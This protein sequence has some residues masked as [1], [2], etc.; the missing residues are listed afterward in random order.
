MTIAVKDFWLAVLAAFIWGATFPITA[1][2]ID[3]T[4]PIF[5]AFLRFATAAVFVIFFPRPKVPILTL[6]ALGLLLGVGQFGVMFV[7]MTK[8]VSAGLASLLVHTQAFF[9]VIIAMIVFSERITVRQTFAMLIA[10]AGLGLFAFDYFVDGALVG[11][12]LIMVAALSAATVNTIFKTLGK[13]DM[14]GVSV[15]MSLASPIPL[16]LFSTWFE[17]GGDMVSLFATINWVVI[18]AAAYSAIFATLLVYTIWGRLLN[19]Y[20]TV[21]VAPFFLLVPIFGLGLSALLLGERLSTPQAGGA[22]LILLGLALAV[23]RR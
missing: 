16:L 6:L 20:S 22:I 13:V 18:A 2:A 7:S 12:A 11:L 15:W 3:A 5:F 10:L 23:L 9:T 1:V 19:S 17:A 14:L 21:I 8:G 4:P